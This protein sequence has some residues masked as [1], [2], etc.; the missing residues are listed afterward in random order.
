[1]KLFIC[2]LLLF[3]TI[4]QSDEGFVGYGVGM[5]PSASTFFAETKVAELGLRNFLW[6]GLYWQN[7]IGF[8]KDGSNDPTRSS[9][10]YASSG[11]GLEVDL[12]PVELRSGS[13]LTI[14]SSP[15]SYLGGRFPQFSTDFYAG[16][17]DRHGNGI[18]LDYSHTSSAGIF[19]QNV[20]RDFLTLQLSMK[21]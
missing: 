15:D 2:L 19:D 16:V 4:C 6:D 8:W 9:S 20:G 5:G 1:M 12:H 3:S 7:K 21:W 17:R 14:I 18:G 13:G 10:L 11:I